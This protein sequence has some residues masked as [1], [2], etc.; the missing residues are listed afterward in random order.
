MPFF[1]GQLLYSFPSANQAKTVLSCCVEKN[2]VGGLMTR[3]VECLGSCYFGRIY[4]E[5]SFA[6]PEAETGAFIPEHKG[7]PEK[8]HFYFSGLL[9]PC[10]HLIIPGEAA[11]D[12][13]RR[14]RTAAPE[15]QLP[16][17]ALRWP[18]PWLQGWHQ[19]PPAALPGCGSWVTSAT[20]SPGNYVA[21]THLF[22]SVKRYL[23]PSSKPQLHGR[24]LKYALC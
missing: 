4:G 18:L 24:R 6:K 9:V 5:C 15:Q 21:S 23:N 1:R 10:D 19:M 7:L 3:N 17:G 8:P 13:A 16:P 14:D 22:L 12:Q 2:K 11:Q 20:F